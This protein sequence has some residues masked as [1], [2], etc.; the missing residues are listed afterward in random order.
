MNEKDRERKRGGEGLK[1]V[2]ERKC[3]EGQD[4]KALYIEE[5]KG[6]PK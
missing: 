6:R 1:R 3:R 4:L 5:Q 2:R